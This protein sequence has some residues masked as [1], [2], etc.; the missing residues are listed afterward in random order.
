MYDIDM[1]IR[2]ADSDDLAEISEVLI[3]KASRGFLDAFLGANAADFIESVPAG[4]LTLAIA[5]LFVSAKDYHRTK[6]LRAFLSGLQSG[7]KP[8]DDFE[9]LDEN[10]KNDLRG[11]VLTQLDL[12]A[13]ERQAEAMGLI[14]DAYLAKKID[15]LIFI[16]IVFEIKNTNPLL[17]Y[18]SVDSLTIDTMQT[19]FGKPVIKGSVRLLPA[20][21]YNTSAT[22][23]S[24]GWSAVP[25]TVDHPTGMGEAFF[26]YIY[27][28]MSEKYQI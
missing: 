10:M 20:V 7:S 12:Q 26:K 19:N 3:D 21:F 1:T 13:D 9:E 18:F 5:K 14:V 27:D 8:F 22:E 2:K 16:G 25:G 6:M 11:L 15:R 4:K 17:Y 23:G 28:P 24:H